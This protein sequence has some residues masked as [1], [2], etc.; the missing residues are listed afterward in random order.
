MCVI[1][2]TTHVNFI[3]KRR[4]TFFK[5]HFIFSKMAEAAANEPETYFSA[6]ERLFPDVTDDSKIPTLE[7][8]TACQGIGE[9]T[10]M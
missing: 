6:P 3:I 9:F 5:S 2:F 8:L 7:F 1:D 4:L 10:G